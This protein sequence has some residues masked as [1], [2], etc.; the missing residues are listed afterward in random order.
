MHLTLLSTGSKTIVLL[1]VLYSSWCVAQ[2]SEDYKSKHQ[3]CLELDKNGQ[4]KECLDCYLALLHSEECSS[5]DSL[6]FRNYLNVGI[7][8]SNLY[9]AQKGL[10]YLD[11]SLLY[12]HAI[13]SEAT[14]AEVYD[15]QSLCYF[16]LG[17][18]KQ[19]ERVLLNAIQIQ[20]D[21]RDTTKLIKHYSFMITLFSEQNLFPKA[22]VYQDK[23]RE[24]VFKKYDD[25]H[26]K[27]GNFF[28]SE[29]RYYANQLLHHKAIES[30]KK[31]LRIA[32]I[33]RGKE[34]FR[35]IGSLQNIGICYSFVGHPALAEKYL[36]E[37]LRVYKKNFPDKKYYTLSAI[38]GALSQMY[39]RVK[40][41]QKARL[42]GE[43]H[44][45]ITT[46][47]FSE[48]LDNLLLSYQNIGQICWYDGDFKASDEYFDKALLLSQKIYGEESVNEAKIY[49]NKGSAMAAMHHFEPA[50]K[51]YKKE[52]RIFKNN[53]NMDINSLGYGHY[54]LA[55]CHFHLNEL[56]SAR[57]H[58]KEAFALL[59][60]QKV[61]EGITLSFIQ[62]DLAQIYIKQ[63]SYDQAKSELLA[64]EQRMGFHMNYPVSDQDIA[65]LDPL[66]YY[67]Q[68]KASFLES[69]VDQ[70]PAYF[71]S[72][73]MVRA[74]QMDVVEAKNNLLVSENL[75]E[76]HEEEF[77]EYYESAIAHF[78]ELDQKRGSHKAIL[79]SER[80]K[81]M[82]LG[83]AFQKACS[84]LLSDSLLIQ[85]AEFKQ[86]IANLEKIILQEREGQLS[87]KELQDSLFT[88]KEKRLHLLANIREQLPGYYNLHHKS[89]EFDLVQFQGMLSPNE[90]FLEYFVTDSTLYLFVINHDG[91]VQKAIPIDFSL[92]ALVETMR[93]SIFNHPNVVEQSSREAIELKQEYIASA[94]RLFQVLIVPIEEHLKEK[95]IVATDGVLHFLPFEALLTH[96][97]STNTA[98]TELPYWINE[99]LISY[100][101]SAQQME[102][103]LIQE[104]PVFPKDIAAFA[105][106][107]RVDKSSILTNYESYPSYRYHFA[108]LKYNQQEAKEVGAL[109]PNSSNIFT[110][111]SASRNQFLAAA[112][113]HSVLHIAAHGKT[114]RQK[115]DYSFIAF[116]TDTTSTA[117]ENMLFADDIYN[118]RLN[119]QMVVLSACETGIGELKTGAG[120]VSLSKALAFAGVR[121][122]VSTL[123]K[124]EDQSTG[125]FMPLFYQ[126]LKAGEQKHAALRAAKQAFIK[127]PKRAAPFY[128]AG[129]VISGDTRPLVQ[130]ASPYKWLWF[131]G[132]PALLLFGFFL[133]KKTPVSQSR[134]QE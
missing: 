24:L 103:L 105:P 15:I 9:Q 10:L 60:L 79:I 12:R 61:N 122:Q 56:D 13:T 33:N 22:K 41:F 88:L 78:F 40:D 102:R 69:Q 112:Q 38:Y 121:S 109:F 115:G 44:L 134:E 23:F 118:S 96:E 132:I 127:D 133:L 71:D 49:H 86:Q 124:I 65:L 32:Q 16:M 128:W 73:S 11:S 17:Q 43:K 64:I 66:I 113:D 14:V 80:T 85:E 42:Y 114:Y 119:N 110:G 36:L 131:I 6:L 117:L 130:E 39:A 91:I 52:I 25:N 107:Y 7:V 72:L 55:F 82:R 77:Y 20:S 54:M 100:Q 87:T 129:Y 97:V 5:S 70:H 45:D 21:F 2:V 98:Y 125:A 27:V 75:R 93:K 67:L 1:L 92:N 48:N 106:T 26:P 47:Y 111:A 57:F 19:S 62:A 18:F 126:H 84:K 28:F 123:W 53:P 95:V 59:E 46:S 37:S 104:L 30:F 94:S 35:T 81:K 34:D 99:K 120:V 29:G 116:S 31:S 51:E 4:F 108:P 68:S 83:E 58:Y 50:K 101:S 3:V 63:K 74:T 76:Q 90:S 8:Y 89:N